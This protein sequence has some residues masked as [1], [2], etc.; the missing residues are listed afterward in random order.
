MENTGYSILDTMRIKSI[1]GSELT[2]SVYRT[3][4]QNGE[5][6]ILSA[7]EKFSNPLIQYLTIAI[8][9]GYTDP[10]F[11]TDLYDADKYDLKMIEMSVKEVQEVLKM[12]VQQND[13]ELIHKT[14]KD[15]KYNIDMPV[16]YSHAEIMQAI[17]IKMPYLHHNAASDN[18]C[19]ELWNELIDKMEA[20]YFKS[21]AYGLFPLKKLELENA[22]LST[23]QLEG[24]TV[25]CNASKNPIVN[26]P[27]VKKIILARR[28]NDWLFRLLSQANKNV[29]D[30]SNFV[31]DLKKN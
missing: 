31:T 28:L 12:I 27:A 21:E 16:Y 10:K 11:M 8:Q 24:D 15:M 17:Y 29:F 20:F 19:L 4:L 1:D 30:F 14:I 26:N 5:D 22:L 18:H 6:I 3:A 9:Y 2:F 13:I 25:L 23:L 7:L